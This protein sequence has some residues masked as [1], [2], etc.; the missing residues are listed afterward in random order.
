M[1]T[2][3]NRLSISF[4][5]FS[6]LGFVA[7][8]VEQYPSSEVSPFSRSWQFDHDLKSFGNA[9]SGSRKDV[10]FTLKNTSSDELTVIGQ[11]AA[12]YKH[13]CLEATGLPLKV[14]PGSTKSLKVGFRATSPGPFEGTVTLYISQRGVKTCMLR[15]VGKVEH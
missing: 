10:D 11:E 9:T 15:V 3:L 12:C 8:L 5:C 7:S 1:K 4:A 13:G 14:P 2:S 6:V